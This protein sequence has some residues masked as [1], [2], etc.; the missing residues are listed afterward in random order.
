MGDRPHSAPTRV[1]CKRSSPRHSPPTLCSGGG[2]WDQ[3][4]PVL[5]ARPSEVSQGSSL[6]RQR[7]E[8][9]R[10]ETTDR[11]LLVSPLGLPF[12]FGLLVFWF[13]LL[14]GS[15]IKLWSKEEAW[16]LLRFGSRG[17]GPCFSCICFACAR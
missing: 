9:P 12:H 17:S 16:L 10:G 1:P 2:C 7:K 11:Q 5:S 6:P 4:C 3:P 14:G 15:C 13:T 8:H